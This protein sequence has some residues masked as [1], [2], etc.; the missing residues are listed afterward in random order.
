MV[1]WST[2]CPDWKERIVEGRS[3]IPFDPLFPAEAAAAMQI[4]DDLRIVDAPGSPRIAD[5]GRPWVHDFA[6]AIFGAYEHETGRRLIR[7]FFLLIS[8]KNSKS[9]SAGGIMLT[10]LMRNWRMSAEFLIVAPTLEVA[11]NSFFPARDMVKADPELAELLHVQ[12]HLKQITHR[13]TGATLKVVAADNDTVSGK[14][15]SAVLIDELWLFGK[16]ANA[17][18]MLREAVGGLVARPEGFVAYL[19]TQS[20][21]PPAGVFKQK[22]Q[23]FRD[24]R[25]GKIEDKRSLPV[26]Y[27]FPKE[28]EDAKDYLDPKY[29]YV[30]NPN[31]GAS[32]DEEYLRDELKKAQAAGEE[33]LRGFLAKHLNVEIGMALRADRWA[34]A[35]YWPEAAET[36]LSLNDIMERC[37]VI[38]VGIDGGGLDDLYGLC[39]IGRERS[40]TDVRFRRWFAWN[41]TWCAKIALTRRKSEQSR[42]SDFAAADELVVVDNLDDA[43]VEMADIIKSIDDAGLLA[44]VGMDPVGAK[45]LTDKLECAGVDLDRINAVSQGYKLNGVIVDCERRLF[46]KT[47]IHSGQAIMAWAVSN[48]RLEMKGNA[49]IVTK[50]ASGKAKIDPLMAL[51]DAATLMS[52]N[53]EPTGISVFDRLATGGVDEAVQADD[54]DQ[55]ILADPKHPQWQEMR[56]RWEAQHLSSDEI[57]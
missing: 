22:L 24:V 8:K 16:R 46:S 44:G 54:I 15:A 9:S 11:N 26:L 2:A 18:N 35:D 21:E 6:K 17:E 40:A 36:G 38:T 19:S 57:W 1:E 10:A 45:S 25:D 53:P 27:E 51:F 32:V 48:A 56:E 33:S 49:V 7:E 55:K 14:K 3:L 12:E 29:F 4:F 52:M 30:T 5:A 47:L 37:D 28:M 23:Y 31:L 43:E 13:L 41:R 39:V 50:Q 34:G 42:Y 20:D